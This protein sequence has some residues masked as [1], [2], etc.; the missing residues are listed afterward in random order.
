MRERPFSSW[1]KRNEAI[2]A[3]GLD[4]GLGGGVGPA[5]MMNLRRSLADLG[6]DQEGDLRRIDD[7]AIG[8]GQDE[9]GDI[10]RGR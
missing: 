3:V 8:I 2:E 1:P 7:D 10:D 6:I 9:C 4:E 5:G